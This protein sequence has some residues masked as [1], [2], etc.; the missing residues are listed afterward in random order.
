MNDDDSTTFVASWK[1]WFLCNPSLTPTEEDW[2]GQKDVF[3]I[4][5]PLWESTSIEKS[6]K[7]LNIE[8]QETAAKGGNNS[9]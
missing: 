8:Y 4:W 1:I 5:E 7:V 3:E 6:G 9:N 2:R